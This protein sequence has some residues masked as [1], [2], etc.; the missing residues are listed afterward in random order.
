M[1]VLTIVPKLFVYDHESNGLHSCTCFV[2][3]ILKQARRMRMGNSTSLS[4]ICACSTCNVW[5]RKCLFCYFF[6]ILQTHSHHPTSYYTGCACWD[7]THAC[8]STFTD[9]SVWPIN[10][11]Y[12][13]SFVGSVRIGFTPAWPACLPAFLLSSLSFSLSGW[14]CVHISCASKMISCFRPASEHLSQRWLSVC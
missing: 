9:P 8:R 6:V 12:R 3:L 1:K 13:C 11:P 7:A 2:T 5:A 14:L 4:F 10:S